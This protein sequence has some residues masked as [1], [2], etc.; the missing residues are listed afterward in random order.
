[1]FTKKPE[2]LENLVYKSSLGKS[3][4]VLIEFKLKGGAEEAR[5]E[6]YKKKKIQLQ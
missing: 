1:M 4:H 6:D 3:Y 2:I 5:R